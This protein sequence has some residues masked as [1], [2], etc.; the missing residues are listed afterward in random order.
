MVEFND[1]PHYG[2]QDPVT[3]QIKLFETTG[4][5]EVH[6]LKAPAALVAG[7]QRNHTAGLEN[8]DGTTG[9]LY[10]FGLDALASPQNPKT[11]RYLPD[12]ACVE[13]KIMPVG[14][15]NTLGVGEITDPASM[16]GYRR[17]LWDSLRS[18]QY[19]VNFVG[20]QNNGSAFAGT[21]F[22]FNHEGHSGWTSSQVAANIQSWLA[23]NPADFILL[24][25]GTNDIG[26][27]SPPAIVGD[28]ETILNNID[29]YETNNTRSVKVILAQIINR[30]QYSPD[31]TSLNN[32]LAE[33]VNTRKA[34]GDQI[35]LVDMEEALLYPADLYDLLHPTSSGYGKMAN[36][37]F[38]VLGEFLNTCNAGNQAPNG[39]ID[40]PSGEVTIPAGGTVVFTGSGTDLDGISR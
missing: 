21:G 4:V 13:T 24:H 26:V 12:I 29:T 5:I 23:A 11:V 8:G 40:S 10:Y 32:L 2:G 25:I 3:F 34:A 7:T 1:I 36:Q 28:I 30:Q 35:V 15:S 27:K 31:T 9:L 18:N 16:V 38:S 14:D 33:L 6:Y 19:A 37:W 20:S 39:V 22:D 17:F